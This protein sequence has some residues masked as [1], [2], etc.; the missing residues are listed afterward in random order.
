MVLVSDLVGGT[1]RLESLRPL[2]VG[3]IVN[4]ESSSGVQDEA[5]AFVHCRCFRFDL[6]NAHVLLAFH[7]VQFLR[8]VSC[9]GCDVFE[10]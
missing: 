6:T 8:R 2:A 3:S 7:L 4:I 9:V 5:V 1:D 10:S